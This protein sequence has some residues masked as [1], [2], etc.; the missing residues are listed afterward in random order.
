MGAKVLNQLSLRKSRYLILKKVSTTFQGLTKT[1]LN[2]LFKKKSQMVNKNIQA[3][4]C[5]NYILL[6]TSNFFKP[7]FLK[8]LRG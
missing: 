7:A 3:S 1:Y 6:I 4:T 8:V 2:S 5:K